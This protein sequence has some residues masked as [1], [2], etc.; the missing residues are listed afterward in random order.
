MVATSHT[1]SPLYD[2]DA[3]IAG[4]P[5]RWSPAQVARVREAHA[6]GVRSVRVATHCTEADIAA[7]HIS[8]ARELG[9]DVVGFLMMAHMIPTAQLVEQAKLM[10][11]YGAHCV[12]V[13]DSGGRLTMNDVAQRVQ[14]YREVLAHDAS[15]EPTIAALGRIA[16]GDVQPMLAAEVLEPFYEQLAEWEKL[17]DLYEVMAAHTEDPIARMERLHKIADI[18]E[19][20]LQEFDKGFD[21]WVISLRRRIGEGGSE[22]DPSPD[23]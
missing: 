17:I 19:R 2:F 16:H 18:Y 12:Y 9:F 22:E 23:R 5:V 11:S 13:T 14:A 6:L 20:Q 3:W 15:H 10:E 4:L 21:T 7:Q 8:K 1:P